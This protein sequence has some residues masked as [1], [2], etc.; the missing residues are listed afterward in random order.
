VKKIGEGWQ[1]EVYD[2][3]NGRVLKKRKSFFKQFMTV[4]IQGGPLKILRG[5]MRKLNED[6]EYSLKNLSAILNEGK[7]DKSIFGNPEIDLSSMSYTQDK[8]LPAKY[9][10]NRFSEEEI[11]NYFQAYIGLYKYM[12]GFGIHEKIFNFELNTGLDK[13][14]KLI[15]TDLGELSFK[16]KKAHKDVASK[17]WLKSFSYKRIKEKSA[18]KFYEDTMASELT[19]EY[20]NQTWGRARE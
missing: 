6:W 13:N 18:R 15:L 5:D 16:E 12:W 3:G 11:R 17:R 20:L 14:G 10:L 7:V 9:A 1:C 2:L 4:L 8:I 19:L